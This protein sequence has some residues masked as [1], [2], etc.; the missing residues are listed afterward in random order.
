[1]MRYS[2]LLPLVASLMVSAA[3]APTGSSGPVVV[4]L[5]PEPITEK[6]FK[7]FG[8]LVEQ[9]ANV[10]AN[11][12][13]AAIRR[14]S[15][16]AKARIH[17]D[18]EFGIFEV[19]ARDH[20]VA[21]MERHVKTPMLLVSLREDYL[22]VVAPPLLP[23]ARK[24]A[25]DAAK[26]RV[27]IVGRE[28]AVILKKGTWHTMPFPRGRDGMFLFAFSDGTSRTDSKSKPFKKNETVRF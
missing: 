21:E 3:P 27:F 17:K 7:Q 23:N 10:P 2:L 22:L 20:E 16:L 14:W 13:N 15:G 8:Q 6:A 28:Q 24:P 18:I 25:P 9:P 5:S 4:T 26:A 19:K 12:D 11:P 1:M